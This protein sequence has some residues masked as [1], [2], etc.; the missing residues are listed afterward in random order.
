MDSLP[1]CFNLPKQRTRAPQ[2]LSRLSPQSK[3]NP[4]M[5]LFLLNL[6]TYSYKGRIK[7]TGVGVDGYIGANVK[8]QNGVFTVRN[9]A[10]AGEDVLVT[11][12]TPDSFNTKISL[13]ILVRQD[14]LF[15]SYSAYLL[16]TF[17]N[18]NAR[19]I[20]RGADTYLGGTLGLDNVDPKSNL[21]QGL[22]KFVLYHHRSWFV[23]LMRPIIATPTSAASSE[24]NTAAP[25]ILERTGNNG[26]KIAS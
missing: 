2:T 26:S 23:L 7:V 4:T 21:Q 12:E 17:Q 22:P 10:T 9:T 3:F 18:G 16:I 11:F 14:S 24:Q 6:P 1:S 13:T 5:L 25:I 8:K 19:T 20:Q 15:P